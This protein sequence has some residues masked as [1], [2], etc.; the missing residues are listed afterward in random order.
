MLDF[1]PHFVV[2]LQLIGAPV[3]I[4]DKV[5]YSYGEQIKVRLNTAKATG[6]WGYVNLER[7]YQGHWY[8]I[9]MDIQT[10][11]LKESPVVLKQRESFTFNTLTVKR[12]RLEK[13][14]RCR[15]V[16]VFGD[17]FHHLNNEVE[18]PIFTITQ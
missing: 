5:A 11:G 15:F 2:L 17:D 1:I 9:D 16:L 18:G 12:M 13:N 6:H 4:T 3:I 10:T 14:A 7:F 8:A